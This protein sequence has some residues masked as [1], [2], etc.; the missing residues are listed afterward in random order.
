MG[1]FGT[2]NEH[3]SGPLTVI[4][5]VGIEEDG[6]VE[7]L[8]VQGNKQ[9]PGDNK[10]SDVEWFRESWNMAGAD[11]LWDSDDCPEQP[12]KY[13]VKGKLH[14]WQ[15]NTPDSCDWDEEFEVESIEQLPW[16]NDG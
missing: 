12:G 8:D 3:F 14:S 7:L 2:C 11:I 13:M 10:L 1:L 6:W 16:S 5:G 15:D 9:S 4:V